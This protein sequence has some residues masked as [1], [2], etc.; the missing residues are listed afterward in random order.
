MTTAR[1][2]RSGYDLTPLAADRI[3]VLAESL[4]PD[5]RRVILQHGTERPFCGVFLDNKQQ[6]VYTCRLCGLPLFKSDA[7]FESGTGWPSFFAP[8]DR[9]HVAEIS[10]DSHGMRRVEIRCKRCDGHLG[11]V[12]DDGPPPT[13]QRYC[14]N[15]AS[16][17]FVADGQPLEPKS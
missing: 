13:H 4:T 11:H 6:G 8:F 15:S 7:K 5:E 9:E 16:L 10:D 2:S 3:E 17:A 12:F 14:L 1:A